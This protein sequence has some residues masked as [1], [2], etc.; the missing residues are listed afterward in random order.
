MGFNRDKKI[1][2]VVIDN[3][4]EPKVEIPV[5]IFQWLV[6]ALVNVNFLAY[7]KWK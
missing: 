3:P 4:I 7:L 2:N 6:Y 1:Q 5:V